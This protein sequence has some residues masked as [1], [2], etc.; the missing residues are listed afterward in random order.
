VRIVIELSGRG[1][2]VMTAIVLVLALA[3]PGVALASHQ[4]GDVPNSNP[5][6]NDISA[7]ALAGITTGCG[8]GNFCPNGSLTRAQEA[9]FI[10]RAS[11]RVAADDAFALAVP[12]ATDVAVAALTI[13]TGLPGGT[14]AGANGFL[15]IDG[16]VSL[17][18]TVADGCDCFASINIVVDGTPDAA[19]TFVYLDNN[20]SYQLSNGA[21]TAVVPVTSGVKT[22]QLVVNEYVGSE[23][24]AAYSSLTATYV[25]FGSTGTDTA[26]SGMT[27]VSSSGAAPGTE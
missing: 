7:I 19:E 13:T 26:G 4:F 8:G 3:I 11:G 12:P 27:T 23:T 17:Y 15:K 18:E 21:I 10:H 5:F 24:L 16:T 9:A 14:I 1:R 2:K 20:A 25:P 6:H 22:V